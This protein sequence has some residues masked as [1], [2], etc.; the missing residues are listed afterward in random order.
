MDNFECYYLSENTVH[1]SSKDHIS[2]SQ[3]IPGELL[4]VILVG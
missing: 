2:L 1:D 3:I 4:Q